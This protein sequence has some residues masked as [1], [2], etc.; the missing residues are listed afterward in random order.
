MIYRLTT[1]AVVCYAVAFASS[2]PSRAQS[3][4][5]PGFQACSGQMTADISGDAGFSVTGTPS[6]NDYLTNSSLRN[7]MMD[8]W[9]TCT[10]HPSA[11]GGSASCISYYEKCFGYLPDGS[12]CS[13]DFSNP[14]CGARR[15]LN[16]MILMK[17]IPMN[18]S[19]S[20]FQH[21]TNES[22]AV[23]FRKTCSQNGL[24][25]GYL[26]IHLYSGPVFSQPLVR[27]ASIIAHEAGHA[28]NWSQALHC[29]PLA[30]ADCECPSSEE[31]CDE[32]WNWGLSTNRRAVEFIELTLAH[33]QQG[34][35]SLPPFVWYDAY[36]AANQIL[37][38]RF[39]G[40]PGFNLVPAAGSD[41]TY[42][43]RKYWSFVSSP[44]G[45]HVETSV[46]GRELVDGATAVIQGIFLTTR[47]ETTDDLRVCATMRKYEA[48]TALFGLD[49]NAR[50][51][52]GV[53]VIPGQTDPED[54]GNPGCARRQ[55]FSTPGRTVAKV[56]PPV[57]VVPRQMGIVGLRARTNGA[58][59]MLEMQA[60]YREIDRGAAVGPVTTVSSN[61]AA[62]P[63]TS[64]DGAHSSPIRGGFL[65]GVGFGAK[66]GVLNALA[67]NWSLGPELE[68]RAGGLGGTNNQTIGAC[69]VNTVP[70]GVAAK[71][72]P[73]PYG[74]DTVGY[75]SLICAPDTW[76]TGANPT[77]RTYVRTSF[78]DTTVSPHV[79]YPD[80]VVS[81][82]ASPTPHPP[83]TTTATCPSGRTIEGLTLRHGAEIDQIVSIQCSTLNNTTYWPESWA[84]TTVPVNVGGPGGQ[85]L[86][87]NCRFAPGPSIPNGPLSMRKTMAPF[88]WYRS[89]W[90]LDGLA[91]GCYPNLY[92]IET[93]EVNDGVFG[94]DSH[95]IDMENGMDVGIGEDRPREIPNLR[96][97]WVDVSKIAFP[98]IPAN[99]VRRRLQGQGY[100]SGNF[101]LGEQW[102]PLQWRQQPEL[103]FGSTAINSVNWH[104]GWFSAISRADV[105]GAML[106]DVRVFERPNVDLRHI[107]SSTGNATL[108]FRYFMDG[109][110]P[111]G[112]RI[113]ARSRGV[114]NWQTLWT[115]V[116]GFTPRS[117]N[118]SVDLMAVGLRGNI[119]DLRI[120]ATRNNSGLGHVVID[121]LMLRLG[122]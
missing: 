113:D 82:W 47:S 34:V 18:T 108:D 31:S 106:G 38:G 16:T 69:P 5:W 13:N 43:T 100:G 3:S 91:L 37:D 59:D 117:G 114:T 99:G 76:L 28:D 92:D 71:A 93:F 115:Y 7:A 98:P 23:Y 70:I 44:S 41:F 77:Q 90:R 72:A 45:Y 83:G 60:D 51:I 9:D 11:C 109:N 116:D 88:F 121:G 95:L 15:I 32:R 21:V 78:M 24:T 101:L 122:W 22:T 112:L 89:G 49:S 104:E 73:S 52:S 63:A 10:V 53:T 30:T 35:V 64:W 39:Q 74:V 27:R 105:D 20:W 75:F 29:G 102:P 12:S 120:V 62:P 85:L 48:E 6:V 61:P 103:D 54:F 65:T 55:L 87:Q 80:A 94:Q 1:L 50:D 68:A 79:Y 107:P 84:Q 33:G 96:S 4:P 119:V 26:S 19:V 14:E 40:H 57:Q 42:G 36:Q 66:N 56:M 81:G 8:D 118:P 17:R 58:G 111:G 67:T 25:D 110:T 97:H 46:S 86:E 2:S